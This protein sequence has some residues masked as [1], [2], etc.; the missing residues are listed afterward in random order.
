LNR[1]EKF[2]VF[3]IPIDFL[4]NLTL[5]LTLAQ[6]NT[7]QQ[8]DPSTSPP[9]LGCLGFP[10]ARHRLRRARLPARSVHFLPHL[11]YS[12]NLWLYLC[13]CVGLWFCLCILDP[14]L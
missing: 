13:P 12:V 1:H 3:D 6:P 14:R 5:T 10:P 9:Q 7:D 4:I 11:V 2:D 8:D